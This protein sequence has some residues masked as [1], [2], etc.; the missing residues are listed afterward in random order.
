MT[1]ILR[2]SAFYHDSAAAQRETCLSQFA[3]DRPMTLIE[4]NR[5]PTPRQVRQFAFFWLSGFCLLLA[6]M[7]A[8]F[9]IGRT[10]SHVPIAA[11]YYLVVTPKGLARWP[12]GRDAL[13]RRFDPDAH[14][15][16]T[17]RWREADPGR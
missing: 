16:W 11:L 14:S 13:A 6:W 4:I 1:A 5:D 12:F 2:I 9:P 7:R 3:L 8:A 10:I 15:Y 17:P